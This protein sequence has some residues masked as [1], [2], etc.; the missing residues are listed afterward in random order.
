ML[1]TQIN[2]YI[3]PGKIQLNSQVEELPLINRKRQ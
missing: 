1:N 2:E 3:R